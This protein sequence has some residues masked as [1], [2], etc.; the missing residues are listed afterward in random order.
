MDVAQ[1]ASV[2]AGRA[3]RQSWPFTQ[4]GEI[5]GTL[6]L[7]AVAKW[8]LPQGY[9]EGYSA[10]ILDQLKAWDSFQVCSMGHRENPPMP[11]RDVTLADCPQAGFRDQA[12]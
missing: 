8:L 3:T 7:A 12:P 4:S 2:A 1:S 9:G 11:S 10:A 5:L 6:S